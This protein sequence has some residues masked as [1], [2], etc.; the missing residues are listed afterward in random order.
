MAPKKS[1]MVKKSFYLV[2]EPVNKAKEIDVDLQNAFE[3]L[4]YTIAQQF[5]IAEPKGKYNTWTPKEYLLINRQEY[6][7]KQRTTKS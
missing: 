3:V 4:Q 5:S 2:G 6:P 1:K 7:F